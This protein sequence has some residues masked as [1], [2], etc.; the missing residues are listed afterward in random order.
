MNN[1]R[2]IYLPFVLIL[3]AFAI[4]GLVLVGDRAAAGIFDAWKFSDSHR[5][6]GIDLGANSSFEFLSFCMLGMAACIPLIVVSMRIGDK[7]QYRL[8]VAASGIY[9]LN[10]V[11]LF[12]LISSGMAYFY[13]GR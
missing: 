6:Q 4:F 13:C 9:F 5:K 3:L 8:A 10:G 1:P 2:K 11:V 7:L 12:S